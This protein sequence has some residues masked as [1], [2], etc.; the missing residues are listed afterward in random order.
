LT[1]SNDFHYGSTE[2]LAAKRIAE[3]LKSLIDQPDLFQKLK[4]GDDVAER[5]SDLHQYFVST[6]EFQ[7]AEEGNTNVIIGPKGSGKTATLRSL[8]KSRGP[9]ILS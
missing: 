4:F 6:Y 2:D 7:Q 8:E 9:V 5:D 1:G 3:R